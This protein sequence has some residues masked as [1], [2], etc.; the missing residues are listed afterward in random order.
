MNLL[1]TVLYIAFLGIASHFI[2]EA[3]PHRFLNPSVF[4]FKEYPF[5]KKAKFYESLKI[6]RWKS[7]LPDMSRVLGDMMPKKVNRKMDSKTVDMLARETCRAEIVH[8]GLCIFAFPI[9][10]IWHNT[11]GLFLSIIYIS[12]NLPFIMIQRY[13][14]PNLIRLRDKLIIREGVKFGETADIVMQYGSGS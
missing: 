13:N 10:F 5:E 7:S 14:R 2:G 12:A 6:K 4:P 11:V 8:I 1:Y 9:Y 3:I